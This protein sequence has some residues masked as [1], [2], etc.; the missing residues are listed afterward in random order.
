MY[1]FSTADGA[2]TVQYDDWSGRPGLF[3]LQR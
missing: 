2:N 1:T 3:T